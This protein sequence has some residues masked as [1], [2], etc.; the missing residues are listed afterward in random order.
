[1]KKYLLLL[2]IGISSFT[3]CNSVP[4][5]D[6]IQSSIDKNVIFERI[7][8]NRFAFIMGT[9]DSI[10]SVFIGKSKI[11]KIEYKIYYSHKG[12]V[13]EDI[14]LLGLDNGKWIMEKDHDKWEIK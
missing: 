7:A 13:Y 8:E 11:S 9:N 3:A 1:M 14:R 6:K 2:F 4:S 12:F 10:K 5:D